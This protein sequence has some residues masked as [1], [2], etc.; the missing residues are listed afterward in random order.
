MNY[1]GEGRVVIGPS[2][3][4]LFRETFDWL[5]HFS[6]TQYGYLIITDVLGNVTHKPGP[7]EMFLNPLE[8]DHI[9][10]CDGSKIDANHMIVVY[11]RSEQ[12]DV[13][14][15]IV[16][17]PTVFMPN[18]NEWLHEFKWHGTDPANKTRMIPGSDVF[19]QLAAIPEQFYYN[20]REV[21][22][23]DDT[24]LTVKLM[25]F[26]ELTDVIKML[27]TTQDPIADMIN[28][29]CADVIAF[30]GKL[31]Y[32]KFV[33]Q[34]DKLSVLSTYPQL[35]QRANSIGYDINKVVYRGYHASDQLEAMQCAAIE[36]RT[37]LRINTDIEEQKQKLAAFKL[38]KEQARM[39]L[40]QEMDEKKQLHKQHIEK[41]HQDHKLED[42]TKQHVQNLKVSQLQTDYQHESL[43][44]KNEQQETF[45][46]NLKDLGVDM[47]EY[48]IGQNNPPISE[49]IRVISA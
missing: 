7:C 34:T 20:V 23:T 30:V 5:Y 37:Q 49:E 46:S 41:M 47:T 11:E 35:C 16:Q 10:A 18:A 31:T 19:K 17:G 28:A 33:Q 6:A 12:S 48:L 45:W 21:R 13:V 14:R 43:R 8:H 40:R 32:E 22:T 3:V 4:F 42:Q 26:Y 39:K 1:R 15:R 24:M 2:R 27:E 25:L 29:V 38:E 9:I 36:A 44:Q